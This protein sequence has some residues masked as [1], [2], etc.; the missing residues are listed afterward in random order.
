MRI[1]AGHAAKEKNAFGARGYNS[2]TAT[3]RVL[4]TSGFH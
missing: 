3:V 2:T 4:Y 1:R